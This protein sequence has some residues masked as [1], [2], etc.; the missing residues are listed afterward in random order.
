MR[1]VMVSIIIPVYNG[2]KT[3]RDCL[4]AVFDSEYRH[5][6]VILVDDNSTDKTLDNAKEFNCKVIKLSR[7]LGAAAARNK[8]V[9]VSHGEI[10]FFL[11]S[12][13]I[14]EKDTIGKIV[15]TFKNRPD[16]IALFG[17]YKKNTIPTNFYSV[18]KN[19]LHHY[20][21]QTSREDAAT[22]CAGFGAIRRSIFFELGGFD[23]NYRCLEDIELGYRMY[24]VG[25]KIYLD[26][27]IQ[28][29]HC[30]YYSLWSLIKS[31]VMNRA[32]PWTKIMLDKRIFRSDLNTK[33]K[34]I[35][36]VIIV[37]LMLVNFSLLFIQPRWLLVLI[38]LFIFFLAL[39][40]TFYLFVLHEKGPWFMVK[41]IFMNWLNYLYS[42]FGFFMG[43]L[44]YLRGTIFKAR[45]EMIFL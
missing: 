37:F 18:Y 7:N 32:K 8:G 30:K 11:D 14:I 44:A 19:L 6:K 16:T 39:N 35:I 15:H 27:S 1:P 5:F 41:T 3:I 29:T 25:H 9:A 36:S 38:S 42:G 23:E 28:V 4:Q 12:D 2:E 21:H 17:S 26:K 45:K 13:I 34:N 20:T 10:L 24:Q 31:D 40:N 43:V 22:F 33:A